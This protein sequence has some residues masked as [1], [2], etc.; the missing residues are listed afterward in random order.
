MPIGDLSTRLMLDRPRETYYGSEKEILGQVTVTFSSKDATVTELFG[1]MEVN[2][3]L[4][5]RSKT[6]IRVRRGRYHVTYRGRAPVLAIQSTIHAGPIRIASAA[7]HTFP[8]KLRFPEHI[9]NLPTDNFDPD[10]HFDMTPN[11][12]LPPT[13]LYNYDTGIMNHRF[14]CFVEY[15]VRAIL[16][17]PG[18]DVNV[19]SYGGQVGLPVMYEQPRVPG[20]IAHDAVMKSPNHMLSISNKYLL[21]EHER[22]SGFKAKTA[23]FFKS[24]A[25]PT[26]AIHAI[27]NGSANLLL[28]EEV[29]FELSLRPDLERSTVQEQPEVK[30]T[31]FRMC[32][33]S[34]TLVRAEVAFLSRV[35]SEDK[36]R[37]LTLTGVVQDTRPFSKANDY[38]KTVTMKPLQGLPSTFSTKNITRTYTV[39][40]EVTLT[41]AEETKHLKFRDVP[42]RI[43]PPA[44]ERSHVDNGVAVGSAT[45]A[46]SVGLTGNPPV[47]VVDDEL[48]AYEPSTSMSQKNAAASSSNQTALPVS[49][50]DIVNV[51]VGAV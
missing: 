29:K 25:Y 51:K 2:V 26:F 35:Q 22:P 48:P 42:V 11:S 46:A 21:P 47:A 24:D 17:V 30:L 38:T 13:M 8:F 6:K 12:P 15:R 16:S 32:I 14:E 44:L 10:P 19:L 36:E 27:L 34:W 43:L 4:E 5:G 49:E 37:Q 31:A 40:F 7:P 3:L 23:A 33:S 9:H 41:V 28:G 39:D 18:I 45:G 1:P 50:D 20:A